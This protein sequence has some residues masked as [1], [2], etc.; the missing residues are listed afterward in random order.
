MFLRF[1]PS[2]T[3]FS[4]AA[5]SVVEKSKPIRAL[6]EI[7]VSNKPNVSVK[8]KMPLNK[9]VEICPLFHKDQCC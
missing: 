7:P 4:V 6:A 3:L 8:K 1:C 5:S 2:L 9:D